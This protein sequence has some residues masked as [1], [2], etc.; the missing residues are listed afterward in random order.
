MHC[1]LDNSVLDYGLGTC[2]TGAKDYLT[3]PGATTSATKPGNLYYG[4]KFCGSILNSY[5]LF[6][7]EN[8]RVAEDIYSKFQS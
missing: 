1:I 3:I 4:S 7:H 6:Q 8:N 2:G 5:G